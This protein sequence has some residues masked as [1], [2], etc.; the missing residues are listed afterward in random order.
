MDA[1]AKVRGWKAAKKTMLKAI[2]KDIKTRFEGREK[3]LVI[4]VVYAG[5]HEEAQ[6]WKVEVE[7]AFPEYEIKYAPLSL[8]VACHI[9]KALWRSHARKRQ[10]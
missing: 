9:G 2:Q 10:K 3:E 1:F 4:G 8:S 6:E 5:N 7:A